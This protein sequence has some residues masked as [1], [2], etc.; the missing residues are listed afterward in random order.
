[1]R[2]Q[3]C[4]AGDGLCRGLSCRDRNLRGSRTLVQRAAALAIRRYL[5]PTPSCTVP[6]RAVTPRLRSPFWSARAPVGMVRRCST[7]RASIQTARLSKLIRPGVRAYLKSAHEAGTRPAA[8]RYAR[9][10][11]SG[12]GY[13]TGCAGG[14][15]VLQEP[16]MG[17][18]G[19]AAGTWPRIYPRGDLVGRCRFAPGSDPASHARRRRAAY[20]SRPQPETGLLVVTSDPAAALAAMQQAAAAPNA[21]LGSSLARYYR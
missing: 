18:N 1:V 19:W 15:A 5:L 9:A 20:A 10:L 21:G 6:D 16:P 2:G 4:S 13:C 17:G 11:L 12:E 8:G 7:L 14:I 3:R